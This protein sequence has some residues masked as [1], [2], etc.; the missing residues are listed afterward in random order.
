[1]R[2]AIGPIAAA[3]RDIGRRAAVVKP[4]RKGALVDVATSREGR[5][6]YRVI[7]P[8]TSVTPFHDGSDVW[9]TMRRY[10]PHTRRFMPARPVQVDRVVRVY[11]KSNCPLD[12][13]VR[14]AVQMGRQGRRA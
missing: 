2:G 7:V 6:L 8:K 1:M 14:P 4:L 11:A 12:L 10:N 13:P 9:A 5:A 3:R